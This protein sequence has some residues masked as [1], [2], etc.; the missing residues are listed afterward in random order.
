MGLENLK[1]AFSNIQDFAETIV[2]KVE[3]VSSNLQTN[4]TDFTSQFSIQ[5]EPQEVDVMS[6]NDQ[7]TGFRAQLHHKDLPEFTGINMDSLS[8]LSIKNKEKRITL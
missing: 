1:S 6:N 8:N 5:S 3:D 4:V 2:K 7:V